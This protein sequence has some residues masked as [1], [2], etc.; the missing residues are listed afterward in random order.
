[1]FLIV[2]YKIAQMTLRRAL[3]LPEQLNLP[4][5][6]SEYSEHPMVKSYI[7]LVKAVEPFEHCFTEPGL[8]GQSLLKDSI[9]N[10]HGVAV[11]HWISSTQRILDHR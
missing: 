6:I 5:N 8:L 2:V 3:D 9:F 4:F 1:M 7:N 10:I 11:V